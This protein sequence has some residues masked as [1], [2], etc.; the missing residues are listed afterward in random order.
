MNSLFSKFFPTPAFLSMKAVGLSISDRAIRFVEFDSGENRKE[1]VQKGEV[2]L[3]QGIIEKGVIL[4]VAKLSEVLATVRSS[5][6]TPFV[7]AS[8]PDEKAYV[9]TT[10]LPKTDDANAMQSAVE[11]SIEQNAPLKLEQVTFGFDVIEHSGENTKTNHVDAV[12]SVVPT[13]VI[14]M[15]IAALEGAGFTP[16]SFEIESRAIAHAVI[17]P[18]DHETSI[19][20]HVD[21]TKTALY[22]VQEKVV[23]FSSSLEID[24]PKESELSQNIEMI[25]AELKKVYDY[26]NAQVAADKE[27]GKEVKKI[28]I[29]G[30]RAAND[31]LVKEFERVSPVQ[32]EQA[33]VWTNAFSF[34]EYIPDIPLSESLGFAPAVGLALMAS[35]S[36]N[37]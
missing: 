37:K 9:Y 13:K 26:W 21:D 30:E 11:A 22:V 18:D 23:N 14:D 16:T 4:D 8:I 36:N 27:K 32:V 28:I 33:N 7:A 35:G 12:V 15:Y 29:C 6:G 24:L 5:V 34:D 10:D 25:G 19:V 3:P 17:D 20:V 1:V 2:E 31:A